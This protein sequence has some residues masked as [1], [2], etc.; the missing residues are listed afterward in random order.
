MTISIKIKKGIVWTSK[1]IGIILSVSFVACCTL[2]C[3]CMIWF[4]RDVISEIS[5]YSI[6]KEIIPL[7]AIFLILSHC[8]VLDLIIRNKHA[9]RNVC[10]FVLHYIF[11]NYI[12]I[13]FTLGIYSTLLLKILL[14]PKILSTKTEWWY[15]NGPSLHTM[16]PLLNIYLYR[17]VLRRHDLDLKGKSAVWLYLTG[18]L[19]YTLIVCMNE[20]GRKYLKWD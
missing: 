1:I 12:M 18:R 16:L 10:Y 20:S 19:A 13:I 11:F 15:G 17:I 3:A 14:G 8:F 5:D 7:S 6:I 9:Y 4:Y 2:W